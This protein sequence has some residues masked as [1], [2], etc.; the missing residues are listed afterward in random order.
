MKK[1]NFKKVVQ[2]PE[3]KL[4]DFLSENIDLSKQK[5][6][7]NLIGGG[8][9]LKKGNSNKLLRI[10]R[11]TTLLKK[12]DYVEFYF[13]PSIKAI[14]IDKIIPIRENKNWGVW[15][16]LAGV[17][18]QGTKFGD[19]GSIFRHVEKERKGEI[20]LIH[21]LDRE[22]SGLILFAYTKKSAAKFSELIKNRRL[23]KFYQAEVKG[24]VQSG[25]IDLPLNDKKALTHF[26]LVKNT[27]LGSYVKINLDTGRLH[28]IRKHFDLI[29]HPLLGDPKYGK[30]NK[31]KQGLM[32][33][34]S[35]LNFTD[36]FTSKPVQI[37]L[38]KELRLF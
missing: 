8:V 19:E 6:K 14:N 21:R 26:E 20:F 15:Y 3:I 12:T 34:A 28:Q 11:A 33:V 7:A 5:I 24:Q 13:D 27:R 38:P 9:W 10:R 18:S 4:I 37:E 22:T 23:E 35:E 17:L 30:G 36:P 25:K 16:K 1:I 29:G 2:V 31:N 32:L